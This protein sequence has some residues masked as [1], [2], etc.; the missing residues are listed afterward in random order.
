VYKESRLFITVTSVTFIVNARVNT[1]YDV[2]CNTVYAYVFQRERVNQA[3][4]NKT[5]TKHVICFPVV[6]LNIYIIKCYMSIYL[7]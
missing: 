4:V 2:T 1:V 6:L 7:P 3:L 5:V